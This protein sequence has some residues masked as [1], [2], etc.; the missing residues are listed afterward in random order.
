MLSRFSN[1]HIKD[2]LLR[3]AEDGS[4]KLQTTMRAVLLEKLGS[5]GED[6]GRLPYPPPLLNREGGRD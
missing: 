6:G 4:Q 2:T 5:G 3:L 1:P